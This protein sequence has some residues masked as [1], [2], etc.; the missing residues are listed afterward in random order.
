[1]H[2][3]HMLWHQQRIAPSAN[4]PPMTLSGLKSRLNALSAARPA[5]G[6]NVGSREAPRRLLA[7]P[8]PRG[9]LLCDQ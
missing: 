8:E 1:M 2:V 3:R 9:D 4:K 5:Q 7:A 6:D